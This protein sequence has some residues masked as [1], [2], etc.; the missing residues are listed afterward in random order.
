[1]ELLE[2]L[3][4]PD[5]AD[6]QPPMKGTIADLPDS[7]TPDDPIRP[8]WI[9]SLKLTASSFLT[10]EATSGDVIKMCNDDDV[11]DSVS[12]AVSV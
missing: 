4:R 1:M 6:M 12:V 3:A 2:P 11:V 9:R 8:W 7:F 5:L 10:S